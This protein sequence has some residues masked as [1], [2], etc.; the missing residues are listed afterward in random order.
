MIFHPS[1]KNLSEN[2]SVSLKVNN[3]L[4][5]PNINMTMQTCNIYL[6]L[7]IGCIY[8]LTVESKH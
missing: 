3:F 2:S 5:F 1:K 4:I 7:T 8:L 6:K